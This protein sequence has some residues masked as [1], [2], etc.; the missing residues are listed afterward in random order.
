MTDI[1]MSLDDVLELDKIIE[2]AN[3]ASDPIRVNIEKKVQ[4]LI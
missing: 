3:K 4:T 2:R 1:T